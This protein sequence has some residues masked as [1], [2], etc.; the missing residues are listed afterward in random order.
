MNDFENKRCASCCSQFDSA[1]VMILQ[2]LLET[3]QMAV[4]VK[5][6]TQ[7]QVKSLF[8]CKEC[9]SEICILQ[10]AKAKVISVES[11]VIF[12]KLCQRNLFQKLQFQ[13]TETVSK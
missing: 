1:G 13:D 5:L 4:L 6:E 11:E 12:D 7:L 8:L 2:C 9:Y 3:Y 10:K